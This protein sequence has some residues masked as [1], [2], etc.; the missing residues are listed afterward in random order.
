[1][2]G[3]I[4]CW[5]ARL[6]FICGI[7]LIVCSGCS[8][9]AIY[10]EPHRPAYHFTPAIN[11]SNDP[12]G[13]V[14][15]DGEYHMF[16]QHNPRG[17]KW[18]NLSWGHAVSR[19]LVNWEELPVAIHASEFM[20]FSGSAV[21]DVA[22]T[23]RLGNSTTP[24]LV[25]IYTGHHFRTERQSQY[26]AYSND[27][28]RSWSQYDGN[29]IIDRKSDS[30]R[31]PK[32]LWHEPSRQWVMAITLASERKILFYTSPD[33]RHWNHVSEFG[34]FGHPDGEWECPDL[35][36]L[37]VEGTNG[38]HKWVLVVGFKSGAGDSGTHYFVGNFDGKTFQLSKGQSRTTAQRADYGKDF[39]AAQSW[40]GLPPSDPR[41]IWI[42]WMS[43]VRY[44]EG[45]PTKPWRGA[46]TIP[47]TLSLVRAP[48]GY[49]LKQ[50]PIRELEAIRA[51]AIHLPR[52]GIVSETREL[53][54]VSRLGGVV[55]ISAEL[56]PNTASAIGLRLQ[57]GERA[58]VTVG[59]DAAAREV[60]VD[61]I[62]S[63]PVFHTKFP[64][65]HAAPLEL[66]D[67]KVKLRI[68]LDRSSIELFAAGGERV[69]TDLLFPGHQLTK[70]AAYAVKGA[71]ELLDV[72]A[73]RL[74]E[75]KR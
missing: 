37:P 36:S 3:I 73:W 12:N 5:I 63:G 26:I 17:K 58:V 52:V 24:P 21:V 29:P 41:T 13:L 46:M 42:A 22:N 25:A 19:D 65:R 70:V 62:R 43:N 32:V 10:D 53:P 59:Y 39:Y 15:N 28:G 44:A 11:W 23:S 57:F 74:N 31:D 61:R 67:E 75:M 27:R 18:G 68:F 47:R 71:A 6:R 48:E 51:E 16:F 4:Q 49:R 54:E 50:Q 40:S 35:L 33:L 8:D 1:M 7:S 20:I 34:P 45:T 60:F 9:A 38:E 14:Y 56:K 55:E 2:N 69:I 30:F 64:G 72:R 66:I